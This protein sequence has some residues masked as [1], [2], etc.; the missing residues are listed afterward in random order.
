MTMRMHKCEDDD[1]GCALRPNVLLVLHDLVKAHLICSRWGWRCFV[2]PCWSA[3][4]SVLFCSR[5]MIVST[6]HDMGGD[7]I[8]T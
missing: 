6:E 7:L 4:L 8:I 2:S 1:G 3:Y 5:L